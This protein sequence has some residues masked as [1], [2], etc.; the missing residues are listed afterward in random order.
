LRTTSTV[1]GSSVEVGRV[2]RYPSLRG[3]SARHCERSEDSMGGG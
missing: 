3:A 2:M 1:T